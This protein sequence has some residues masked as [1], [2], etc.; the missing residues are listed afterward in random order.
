MTTE[1]LA[2]PAEQFRQ[3]IQFE[4]SDYVPTCEV[5][6][7]HGEELIGRKFPAKEKLDADFE[8]ACRQYAEIY[9]ESMLKLEHSVFSL[10]QT[11]FDGHPQL[12]HFVSLFKDL[13]KGKSLVQ[14]ITGGTFSLNQ[15]MAP[16]KDVTAFAVALYD[17]PKGLHSE[18]KRRCD[19]A[20]ERIKRMGDGGVD[21]IGFSND[22]AFNSGPFISPAHFR[23]FIMPYL[24]EQIQFARGLGM[25]T[26]IHTDGNV[27]EILADI[28]RTGPHALQS[29]DPTGGLDLAV[30][31]AIL[32]PHKIAV[33]GNVSCDILERGSP[34]AIASET[35]RALKAGKPGGG[36][37]LSSANCIYPEVPLSHYQVMLDVWRRERYYGDQSV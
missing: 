34:D 25:L 9:A 35:R 12:A 5:W 22:Y 3:V 10:Y 30:V 32:A 6:F 23:E 16:G 29:I 2:T 14:G 11:P 31:K 15:D 7:A 33:I 8:S 21:V 1:H 4:P 37:V 20:K 13:V 18:A 28:A 17:D 26:Y 27:M 24:Q 19:Q 36:F